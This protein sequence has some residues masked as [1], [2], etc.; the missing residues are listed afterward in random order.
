MLA[1][2]KNIILIDFFSINNMHHFTLPKSCFVLIGLLLVT[3]CASKKD[4]LYFQDADVFDETNFVN[5]VGI[6]QHNDILSITV[7]ALVQETTIPY[8]KQQSSNGIVPNSIETLKIQGY[9]VDREGQINFPVLGK[10]S[11]AGTTLG[12]AETIL[13]KTLSDG[14]HLVGPKVTIRILNAK[15]TV[16]G[17]VKQP[18]TFGFTEQYITLPQ[19]LGYAGDLTINGKRDDILLI[20]QMNGIRHIY[21]LDLTRTNWLNDSTYSIRQNDVIVV[22]P[23]NAKLKSAGFVGNSSTVLTIASLILSSV[24]LLT[25]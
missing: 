21:H 17:E 6:I 19:A 15:V 7:E 12:E 13:E 9:L 14:G 1:F 25:R 18:G 2:F 16:L 10:L 24:V 20:R 4:M 22:N 23:N 8:N 5:P 11:I 3:S